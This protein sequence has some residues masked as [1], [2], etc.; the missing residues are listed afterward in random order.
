M[1]G[2]YKILN[3]SFSLSSFRGVQEEI[4]KRTISIEPRHSLVLMPTGGGKSLCYQ[5]PGMFFDGGTLVISPLISLMKD[6]GIIGIS[7][8]NRFD[9]DGN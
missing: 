4:I 1:K 5:V 8:N 2:I 7:E 3:D 6:Q 9:S